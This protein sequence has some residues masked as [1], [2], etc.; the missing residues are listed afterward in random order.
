MIYEFKIPE[1]VADSVKMAGGFNEDAYAAGISVISKAVNRAL[2]EVINIDLSMS[3]KESTMLKNGDLVSVPVSTTNLKNAVTIEGAVV[4]PGVYG[5]I[6]G[7][8]IS[9]LLRSV[10]GDLKNYADLGYCLIVRQKNQ[11]LD[12]EV[13]QIDL[14]SAII[15][16]GS[17]D[18]IE[19]QPR[20]K[21]VVFGI[22][23]VT[24]LSSLQSDE[25][26]DM[27]LSLDELLS[28][29]FEKRKPPN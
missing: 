3:G 8:R 15:N 11:R 7:Q 25:T 27:Q 16:K 4:R 24:D 19:T 18:D 28:D 1:T 20:D 2:P 22:A 29:R 6:E 12:I 9:D 26:E 21:V 23:N 13:L 5:W 17:D 10:D 14:A